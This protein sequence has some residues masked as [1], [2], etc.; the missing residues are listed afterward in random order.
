MSDTPQRRADDPRIAQLM[1]EMAEVK[2]TVNEVKEILGSFKVALK[3]AKFCGAIAAAGTAVV[4]FIIS[5]K[6]GWSTIF[7]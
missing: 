4:G 2:V 5:L 3:L 1:T 6:S 7:K